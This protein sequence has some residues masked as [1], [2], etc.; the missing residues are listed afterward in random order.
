VRH[1]C[2]PARLEALEAH[3]SLART[4]LFRRGHSLTVL[5]GSGLQ[6]EALVQLV[7][8]EATTTCTCTYTCGHVVE[9][10]E[11]RMQH[12]AF[13]GGLNHRCLPQRT[14]VVRRRPYYLDGL[15]LN[16]LPRAPRRQGR[17]LVRASTQH[18]AAAYEYV[19]EAATLV[20]CIRSCRPMNERLQP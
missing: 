20:L 7:A 8:V 14:R 3:L 4:S 5:L 15:A 18:E 6:P 10:A 9:E 11:G 1:R 19:L 17:R 13:V 16:P 12:T 2:V